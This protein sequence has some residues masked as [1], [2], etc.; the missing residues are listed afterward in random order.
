VLHRSAQLARGDTNAARLGQQLAHEATRFDLT[1]AIAT[2][3]RDFLDEG[4]STVFGVHESL[5]LQLAIRLHHRG[6]IDS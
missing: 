4:A 3:R 2:I 5:Y 6:G 1:I